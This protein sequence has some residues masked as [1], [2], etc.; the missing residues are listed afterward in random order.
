MVVHARNEWTIECINLDYWA[1]W[2]QLTGIIVES[3]I[4]IICQIIWWLLMPVVFLT[5]LLAVFYCSYSHG[6]EVFATNTQKITK[7]H[8]HSPTLLSSWL[9]IK[10]CMCHSWLYN[11]AGLYSRAGNLGVWKTWIRW[12]SLETVHHSVVRDFLNLYRSGASLLSFSVI[13]V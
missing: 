8:K 3:S 4:G 1:I 6:N 11:K 10:T 5:Y 13:S 12:T 7:L 2:H 9:L